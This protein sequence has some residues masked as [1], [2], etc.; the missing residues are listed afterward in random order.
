[1]DYPLINKYLS[2]RATEEEVEKIFVWIESS[3][4][5]KEIFIAYKKIY[6][7]NIANENDLEFSWKQLSRKIKTRRRRKFQANLLKYAAVLIIALGGVYF[8]QYMDKQIVNEIQIDE[9]VITLQLDNGDI[10]IINDLGEHKIVDSKGRIVGSQKGTVLNYNKA[11]LTSGEQE[12]LVYNELKIPYGKI[13]KLMLSDGTEVYL[14]AGSSLRYP[15]KFIKGIKRQVFL[16]GEAYFDVAKDVEHPFVVNMNSLNVRV[17][18][19]QFN[20]SSYPEDKNIN[21]VLVEGSVSL[22]ENGDTFDSK[23]ASL[24]KP[25]FKA[26]W[27]KNENTVSMKSVDTDV[28][29]GWIEGKIVFK[30]L[31][32]SNIRKKLERHYNVVIINNNKALDKNTYNASFDIETIEEVLES[33]NQLYPIEYTIKDDKILIN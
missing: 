3:E 24:L 23:S 18:G 30:N 15:I 33:L 19:T 8:F 16:T 27:S 5:N 4:Q 21:T 25:G 6:A 22:F 31:S 26:E 17:L 12:E 32:F 2:G 20:I 13:F 10:E 28:Y 29:T 11:N 7:F 1:M 14:N 9:D